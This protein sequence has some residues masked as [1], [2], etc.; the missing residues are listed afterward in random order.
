MVKHPTSA[1]VTIL[2]FESSSPVSG[3]VLTARSLE[4]LQILCLPL[5]LLLPHSHSDSV[6]LSQKINSKTLKE[7]KCYIKLKRMRFKKR[8]KQGCLGGSVG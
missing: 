6:S 4:L 1:Q 3:S 5:S 2:W 7:I 8:F